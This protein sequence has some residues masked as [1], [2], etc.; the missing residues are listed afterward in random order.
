MK[1]NKTKNQSVSNEFLLMEIKMLVR[2]NLKFCKQESTPYL[3]SYSQTE[4]G[5]KDI[6]DFCV[7]AFFETDMNVSE[8]LIMK[9]NLLNPNYLTD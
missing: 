7:K 2:E 6:E 9:E 4:E 8:A 3:C 5:Y 1:K